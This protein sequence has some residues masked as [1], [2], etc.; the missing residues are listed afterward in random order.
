MERHR[1]TER[2]TERGRCWDRHRG[3]AAEAE[4]GREREQVEG[5]VPF[6]GTTG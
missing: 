3:E 6:V 2:G 4:G 1:H 5:T